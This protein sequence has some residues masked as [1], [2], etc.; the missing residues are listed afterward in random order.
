MFNLL[1][2]LH[3]KLCTSAALIFILAR[4][5]R[6]L[7]SLLA[8]NVLLVAGLSSAT[9]S[10]QEGTRVNVSQ[11]TAADGGGVQRRRMQA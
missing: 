10:D 5:A 2:R 1:L 11:H 9:N 4:F 6:S 3:Q 7:S 8:L